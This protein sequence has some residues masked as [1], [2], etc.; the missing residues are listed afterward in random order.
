MGYAEA[1]LLGMRIY[2][3]IAHD[4]EDIDRH[5]E[6][7]LELRQRHIGE[8]KYRRKDGS[9]IVVDTSA[10]VISYGGRTALCA[11]SRDVTERR[12]AE[13]SLKKS[14]ASLAEAQHLAHL[15]GWEWDIETGEVSWSDEIYRIY[16]LEPQS[17]VPGFERFMQV[18]HPD[19]RSRLRK[20]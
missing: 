17:I 9:V 16:G 8:R 7:S 20:T 5:V 13:E 11:V 14:E 6:R 3:I 1:D 18:V 12:Q 2:D 19:D 15:G 10:S 4:D